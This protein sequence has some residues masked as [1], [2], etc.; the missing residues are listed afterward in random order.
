MSPIKNK[1]GKRRKIT[2]KRKV[3]LGVIVLDVHQR[4]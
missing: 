2:K 3:V 1:R 4:R